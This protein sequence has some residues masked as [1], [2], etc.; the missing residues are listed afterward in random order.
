M[1]RV[2]VIGT[3]GSGKTT[4]ARRL[5]RLL[6]APHVELDALHWQ[7]N[8]QEAPH[9]IFLARVEA[10]TAEPR[11]VVDGN[12][13]SRA[14]H[15]VWPRADTVVWLNYPWHIVLWRILLRTARRLVLNEECCN[16]NHESWRRAF[17]RDSII[18]W[19]LQSYWRQQ[20][21][22]PQRLQA[23]AHADLRQLRFASPRAAAQ[24]LA[25]VEGRTEFPP[26]SHESLPGDIKI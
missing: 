21:E 6:G 16:G 11:W 25:E 19:A 26:L 8:W 1:K 4:L 9:E 5:A 7:P 22:F 14:S 23:A 13:T 24:W 18:L 10:A 15:I 2:V 3:S 12:Y 17:S 20:R